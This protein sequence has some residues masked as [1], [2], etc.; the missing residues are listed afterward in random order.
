MFGSRKSRRPRAAVAPVFAECLEQRLCLTTV[1]V[2][3]MRIDGTGEHPG[4]TPGKFSFYASACLG[5]D[6]PDSVTV[7]YDLSGTATQ[8]GGC[9]GSGD[10]TGDI[11]SGTV[12]IP[13][14]GH[15]D[16]TFDAVDDQEV[17]DTET[18]IV[19]RDP[20][21]G[22]DD[23]VVFDDVAIA[24]IAD[25]D[26]NVWVEPFDDEGSE[27]GNDPVSFEIFR[28]GGGGDLHVYYTLGGTATP[29]TWESGTILPRDADYFAGTSFS[30]DYFEAVIPAGENSVVV[31]FAPNNDALMEFGESVELTLIADQTFGGPFYNPPG[32][33]GPASA[34]GW[35]ADLSA[36]QPVDPNE[37]SAAVVA[38]WIDKLDDLSQQ[39]RD[40]ASAWL[41]DA[42]AAHP[43]IEPQL[44]QA[45]D[46]ADG[47]K[48]VRLRLILRPVRLTLQGNTI[49]MSL[50]FADPNLPPGTITTIATPANSVFARFERAGQNVIEITPIA[51]S[52]VYLIDIY[53]NYI[54]ANG[55]DVNI[56]GYN[57]TFA[58]AMWEFM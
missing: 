43:Q 35:I 22:G 14:R 17:E 10:Y 40:D 45:L 6:V 19:T 8:G 48:E 56:P 15:T 11:T 23:V 41:T 32:V 30:D 42:F 34:E 49:V 18:V 26:V 50:R 39:V 51:T 4:S 38:S 21:S 1:Y 27:L 28:H 33:E 25:D 20:S 58:F 37:P 12:T 31:S 16:V 47:E 5:G 13:V 55:N 52:D 46:S 57:R 44:D 2:G 29:G 36:R 3:V 24:A 53:V 54:D 7:S 9:G